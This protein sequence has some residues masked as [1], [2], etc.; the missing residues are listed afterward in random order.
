LQ[1][2]RFSS[3]ITKYYPW[4]R[5]P[6]KNNMAKTYIFKNKTRYSIIFKKDMVVEGSQMM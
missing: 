6:Q 1:I 3:I 2:I 4:Q 5:L